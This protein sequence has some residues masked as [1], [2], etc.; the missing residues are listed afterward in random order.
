MNA[1]AEE[2]LKNSIRLGR[3]PPFPE[4]EDARKI[5]KGMEKK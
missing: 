1:K 5:L 3:Q 4:F 2:Q